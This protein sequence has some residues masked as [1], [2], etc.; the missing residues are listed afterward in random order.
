[1]GESPLR[2]VN[3]LDCAIVVSKYYIPEIKRRQHLFI[4]FTSPLFITKG[5]VEE[6]VRTARETLGWD[7]SSDLHQIFREHFSFVLPSGETDRGPPY[8]LS[9]LPTRG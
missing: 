2:R 6:T 7:T 5:G 9:W 1:M 4:K 8:K 3:V